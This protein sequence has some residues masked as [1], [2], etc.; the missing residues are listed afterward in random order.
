MTNSKEHAGRGVAVSHRSGSVAVR[1]ALSAPKLMLIARLAR[2]E[3]LSS[4]LIRD[5]GTHTT[6]WKLEK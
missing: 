2:D 4:K 1:G 5:D 6:A 3:R